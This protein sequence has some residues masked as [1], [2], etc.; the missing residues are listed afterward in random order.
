MFTH[1]TIELRY[2]RLSEF[3]APMARVAAIVINAGW[4]LREALVQQDGRLFTVRHVWKL[5]DMNHYQEGIAAIAAH[6]EFPS[7]AEQLAEVIVN[8]TIV[9]ATAAPY[10]P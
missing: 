9:F 3:F 7:L 6:P 1:V 10:A 4:E 2:G 5:R 8:E